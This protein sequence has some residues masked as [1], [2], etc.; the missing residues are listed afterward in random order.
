MTHPHAIVHF[1]ISSKDR[2]AMKKFYGDVFAW[3]FKDYDEMNYTTFTAEGGSPGGFNP[4]T[5]TNPAGT[6]TPY[7]NTPDIADSIK[8]I[9]AAGGT[10]IMEPMEIPTVGHYSM[11]KDPSGNLMALL[12]PFPMED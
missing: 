12:Q 8:K 3:E 7:I 5:D 2:N 9:K 1:E 6:I 11:F 10:V 4:I